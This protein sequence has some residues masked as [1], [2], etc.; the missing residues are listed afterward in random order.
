MRYA[1]TEEIVEC[2]DAKS[3][4]GV[5]GRCAPEGCWRRFGAV[6]TGRGKSGATAVGVDWVRVKSQSVTA[7]ASRQPVALQTLK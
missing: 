1:G 7:A 2:K 3:P 4:M 5:K 6:A